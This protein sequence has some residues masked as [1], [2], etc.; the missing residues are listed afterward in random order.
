M[1]TADTDRIG[2]APVTQP[3]FPRMRS[4]PHFLF[5]SLT[6]ALTVIAPSGAAELGP[7]DLNEDKV[8]PAQHVE[9]HISVDGV[10]D[11]MDW[12]RAAAASEFVQFEPNEGQSPSQ[13]TEVRVLYSE[14]AIYIGARL[15]DTE[16]DKIL[17]TLGRRDGTNQAD[18]FYAS[19]D[20]YF[21]KKTAYT[22]GVNAAGV[23]F[24]GITTGNTDTSWDAVWQS[25]VQI[26]DDGWVAEIRIPLAMLRFL[27]GGETWGVNFRR[28]IPRTSETLEWAMVPR[29][30]RR[31]RYVAAYG[32]LQGLSQLTPARNIQI[33]P[34][35]VNRLD[36]FESETPGKGASSRDM[37]IG[38]DLK[39]GITSNITLDATVNP[40]FGQVESDPAELN[41][42]AFESFF[43]EKRPFFVEGAQIMEFRTDYDG[44]LLYTRRIGAGEPIIGATKLTGRTDGGL[45]FGVLG[46]TTGAE[47]DPERI[48]TLSRVRQEIGRYS[49]I[50]GIGTIYGRSGDD[51]PVRSLTSGV[52]WDLR[53]G[54]NTYQFDGFFSY[55][56][57][58]GRGL[59]ESQQGFAGSVGLDRNRG[60]WTL[61]NSLVAFSDDFNPNDMGRLRRNDFIRASSSVGYQINGGQAFGPFIRG[62]VRG[63]LYQ[64]WSYRERINQGFG[65][66]VSGS[67]VT[68]GY[69]EIQLRYETENVFGGY[70]LY[71][72]RGML[73]YAR[74]VSHSLR[75]SFET[76]SRRVW[77]LEPSVN[78]EVESGGGRD[79]RTSLKASWSA[80]SRLNL[81]LETGV[82]RSSNRTAWMS[83][84]SFRLSGNQWQIGNE[85]ALP[86][87]L[88]ETDWVAFAPGA[89]AAALNS[90][91]GGSR[92]S[93]F[94]KRDTRSADVSLR[95]NVT[96]TS[97]L[98][99]QFYGQ[100]FEA[101][102]Q[103]DAFS[104]QT[105]QDHLAELSSYPKRHDFSLA[106]FQTN[107]VLRWEYRPG[108]ALFIVW[109]QARQDRLT[110]DPLD[111][112]SASPFETN[113]MSQFS[114]TFDLFPR[115][116][117]LIKLNYMFL[118]N[119]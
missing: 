88:A 117:L 81:A 41:L 31:S 83:N 113:S 8:L 36:T 45:S 17:A 80:G 30:E 87:D 93:V 102:G 63:F 34:Y 104:V 24:D 37:D 6:L 48:Y 25:A 79:L 38:M 5:C 69:Q 4:F 70:D 96:F 100:L 108:S 54:E 13:R 110:L 46:A 21:D 64:G 98:S 23:Q 12:A 75:T 77:N 29:N 44:G 105:D 56:S 84:E 55:A 116:A 71:Q 76:D 74:P 67:L 97:H 9:S 61:S 66:N 28:E 112:L 57:R 35:T 2:V 118:P 65:A 89:E 20:S 19:L 109:S 50:G 58:S 101:R 47:F 73:P 106:S 86:E 91:A 26:T 7:G 14:Q 53:F 85:S 115:N 27:E 95:S 10:L 68:K 103:Y 15:F 49:Y 99:L 78:L 72:T 16:P 1:K 107:L 82:S 39:V 62:S 32:R 60:V 33:L 90:A 92:M 22:F 52:D 18:W 40:D 43:P 94:G 11:E 114:D 3:V 51:G 111:Q 119:R 59:D 42:T